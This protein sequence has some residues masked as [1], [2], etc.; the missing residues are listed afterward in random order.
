MVNQ[1]P[2][3][4]QGSVLIVNGNFEQGRFLWWV[5]QGVMEIVRNDTDMPKHG[6]SWAAWFAGYNNANDVLYQTF[7][8]PNGINSASLVYYVRMDTAE[9]SSGTNDY[10]RLQLRNEAGSLIRTIDT[11]TDN[12]QMNT[13]LMRSFTLPNLGQY[14]GQNLRLS[15]EAT[16]NSSLLTDF[17]V[18]DVSLTMNCSAAS[19][20]PQGGAE[21]KGE[22]TQP[23]EGSYSTT[24]LQKPTLIPTPYP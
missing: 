21:S 2:H 20:I 1:R 11:V 12:F 10:L 8:V 15:F 19:S 23:E 5:E 4:H 7:N 13:W 17:F 16:T 22:A 24:P 6:G 3:C 9:T 14:A 18:D